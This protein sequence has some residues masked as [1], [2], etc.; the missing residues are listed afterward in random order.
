MRHLHPPAYNMKDIYFFNW[1]KL[2][3]LWVWQSVWCENQ[4]PNRKCCREKGVPTCAHYPSISL[5]HH[6]FF[7]T[8]AKSKLV[9]LNLF[10]LMYPLNFFSIDHISP[11]PEYE[12]KND[13][14]KSMG[15]LTWFNYFKL[16]AKQTFHSLW[17]WDISYH[18]KTVTL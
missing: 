3:Q 10:L 15:L 6:R 18:Y 2:L 8:Q 11:H 14:Q 7:P 5:N 1:N 16:Y 13:K 4:L 12:I 17:R 9:V